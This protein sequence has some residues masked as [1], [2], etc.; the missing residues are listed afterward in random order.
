MNADFGPRNGVSRT[1]LHQAVIRAALRVGVDLRWASPV[2]RSEGIG[3]LYTDNPLRTSNSA[4][5]LGG[6]FHSALALSTTTGG[7]RVMRVVRIGNALAQR[8]A[9]RLVC[10]TY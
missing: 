3:A 5:G 4:L 8:L 1:V 9:I 6:D 7:T 10:L 2:T